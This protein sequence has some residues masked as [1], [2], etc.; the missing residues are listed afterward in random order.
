LD[1][2]KLTHQNPKKKP[3]IQYKFPIRKSAVVSEGLL[4]ESKPLISALEQRVW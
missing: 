1:Y 2:Q 4:S 3:I